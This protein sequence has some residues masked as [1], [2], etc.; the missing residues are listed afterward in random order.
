M[1]CEQ[2]ISRMRDEMNGMKEKLMDLVTKKRIA[3]E[4]GYYSYMRKNKK[5]FNIR[6]SSND[7]QKKSK[8]VKLYE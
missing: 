3:E 8:A 2:S 1:V 6:S 4:K 7:I 5:N